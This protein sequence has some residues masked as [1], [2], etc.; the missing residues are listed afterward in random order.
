MNNQRWCL[1]TGCRNFDIFKCP[2]FEINAEVAICAPLHFYIIQYIPITTECIQYIM[3]RLLQKIC[4]EN[5]WLY[6][7]FCNACKQCVSLV[8]CEMKPEVNYVKVNKLRFQLRF[9]D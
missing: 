2:V 3:K 7:I 5:T 9:V 4:I 1:A 6:S 8:H